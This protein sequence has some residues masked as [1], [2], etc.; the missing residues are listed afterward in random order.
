MSNQLAEAK[1]LLFEKVVTED[2]LQDRFR[3][4]SEML[5]DVYNRVNREPVFDKIDRHLAQYT[6]EKQFGQEKDRQNKTELKKILERQRELELAAEK[7]KLKE[8]QQEQQRIN[9]SS[10]VQLNNSNRNRDEIYIKRIPNS[11]IEGSCD[12]LPH[13]SADIQSF[14]WKRVLFWGLVSVT[15]MAATLTVIGL[16]AEITVILALSVA[17]SG[18]LIGGGGYGFIS[19]YGGKDSLS[20]S[21]NSLSSSHTHS[22]MRDLSTVPVAERTQEVNKIASSDKLASHS[23]SRGSVGFFSEKSPSKKPAEQATKGTFKPNAKS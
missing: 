1:T 18:L 8:S 20:D 17:G 10:E 13:D 16:L 23:Y 9:Q 2:S 4:I 19:C 12:N 6:R 14:P 22:N 11:D 21:D 5:V 15:L 7:Q 3:S